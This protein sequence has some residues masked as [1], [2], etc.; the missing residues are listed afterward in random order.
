MGTISFPII[1]NRL[2]T[3][4][5]IVEED[6]WDFVFVD[7][8]DHCYDQPSAV[9]VETPSNPDS[10][11]ISKTPYECSQLLLKLREDTESEIIPHY[12]IIMDE[13]SLQDDTVLLVTAGLDEPVNT[14]RAT[15]GASAQAIVLYLTGHRGIEEDIESAAQE[16]DGVYHGR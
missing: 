9:P 10:P 13:R 2:L 5:D 4:S 1:M 7:S 15:F 16:E 3:D 6:T 14:V 11:F 12:F 8:I